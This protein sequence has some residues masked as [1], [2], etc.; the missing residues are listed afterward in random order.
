MVGWNKSPAYTILWAFINVFAVLAY[1]SYCLIRDKGFIIPTYIVCVASILVSYGV[2]ILLLTLF[3]EIAAGIVF[4]GIAFYYTYGMVVFYIYT[5][6]N[7]SLPFVIYIVTFVI[8]VATCFAV[9]IYA[10]VADDFD[11]FYGFSITY[12]VINGIILLYAASALFADYLNRY[13]R[14]N[15]FSAYGS[16]IYK[17][18]PEINSVV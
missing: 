15:F 13:D 1:A 7:K 16:P 5:R 3:G 17:Y 18:N 8:I 10:F 6:M 4:L 12:L 2:G 9:M 11:N 14:P